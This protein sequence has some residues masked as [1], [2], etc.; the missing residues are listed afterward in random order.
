VTSLARFDA[1]F[2]MGMSLQVTFNLVD[3]YVIAKAPAGAEPR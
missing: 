2:A 3:A 1:S